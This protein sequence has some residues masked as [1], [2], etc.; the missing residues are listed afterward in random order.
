MPLLYK[1]QRKEFILIDKKSGVASLTPPLHPWLLGTERE[2]E[3]EGTQR[4]VTASSSSREAE[5][6]GHSQCQ[7]TERETSLPALEGVEGGV[8]ADHSQ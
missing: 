4:D 2:R 8:A 5:G 3:K 7:M 6:G 1:D